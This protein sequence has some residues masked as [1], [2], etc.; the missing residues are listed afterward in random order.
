MYNVTMYVNRRLKLTFKLC[1]VIL[2]KELCEVLFFVLVCIAKSN[3]YRTLG[4]EVIRRF[5]AQL[6]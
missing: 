6:N 1:N 2:E 5:H 3:W 4:P